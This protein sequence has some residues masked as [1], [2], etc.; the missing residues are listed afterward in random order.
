SYVFEETGNV[1]VVVSNPEAV[2][3]EV[4][5]I[6]LTQGN[7][8]IFIPEGFSPNG[9][10][11][12]DTFEISNLETYSDYRLKIFSRYGRLIYEGGPNDPRWNGTADN[13]DKVPSGTYYYVLDLKNNK[14][15]KKGWVYL[16]K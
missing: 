8:E 7:C 4:Y 16:N 9:D 11:H 13:G 15:V 2:C 14:E 12:N 6:S 1:Y 10:G 3:P 5:A